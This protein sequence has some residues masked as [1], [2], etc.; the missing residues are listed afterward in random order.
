MDLELTGRVALVTAASKGLGRASAI[1]LAAEGARVMIASRGEEQLAKTAAEISGATGAQ[2][3]Y[4]A[5]D[6]ADA[7]DLARLVEETQ[8][9]L[10][11]VDVLVNNAG[12]PPPGGFD[13]LDDDK[14]YLAHDLNLMSTVRLF[15]AVLPHM[16]EQGWGRIVTI[17]SSSIRQPIENLLLSNTYR[18]AL[19]GLAKSLAIEFAPEGVL[20]NTVGPGRIATDRVATLDANRAKQA[21]ISVE[22]ARAQSEKGIPLGRYGTAAEFAKVVAF[23][24]SGANT[25]TTGQN[26][27]VDGGMVRAI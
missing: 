5:A 3:E 19:L 27:L 24:A 15:R 25:Y 2:V 6:V 23:L 1:Q 20:I 22:E 17:A 13:A 7:A 10:G 8:Q 16:R 21:G 4:C 14:W 9:R 18:V 11:P 12:G 26:F